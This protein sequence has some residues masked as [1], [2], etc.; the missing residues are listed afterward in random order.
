MGI[1]SFG[2]QRATGCERTGSRAEVSSG[3]GERWDITRKDNA[4]KDD[5]YL[6]MI[7]EQWGNIVMVYRTFRGKDQIIEF[8]ISEQKIYSYPA[9]DY[10]QTLSERTRDHTTG[11]FTEAKKGNQFLL[12]IKDTKNRRLRSYVFDVPE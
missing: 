8:D 10:I 9:G 7:E 6:D 5:P 1:G 3:F 4:M 11:Q 2:V 12:F